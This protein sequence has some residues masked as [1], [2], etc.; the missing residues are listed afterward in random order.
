MVP[1]FFIAQHNSLVW[2]YHI[3]ISY[4]S[5]D[6]RLDR[7]HSLDIVDRAS[8]NMVC[9][10]LFRKICRLLLYAKECCRWITW[11]VNFIFLRKLQTGFQS[12]CTGLHSPEQYMCSL[13][14]LCTLTFVAATVLYNNHTNGKRLH[15]NVFWYDST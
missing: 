11:Q 3:S 5:V 15:V 6:Q 8:R 9:K 1:F 13:F 10:Y 2:S 7:I 14:L 4:F 12:I